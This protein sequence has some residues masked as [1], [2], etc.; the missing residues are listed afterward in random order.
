MG[1]KIGKMGGM[2]RQNGWNEKKSQPYIRLLK[3]EFKTA[4]H[5]QPPLF[6]CIFFR[7]KNEKKN[8]GALPPRPGASPP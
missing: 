2:N 6:S 7:Q 8:K 1:V 3:K 4:T 5:F